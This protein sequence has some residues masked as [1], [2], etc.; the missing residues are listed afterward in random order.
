MTLMYVNVPL[1]PSP[2]SLLDE[3]YTELE[4]NKDVP[5]LATFYFVLVAIGAVVAKSSTF[6]LLIKE[7]IL[8]SIHNFVHN[9]SPF[10]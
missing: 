3:D 4:R 6:S 2:L 10:L 5:Y 9:L 8:V 7:V 1:Q